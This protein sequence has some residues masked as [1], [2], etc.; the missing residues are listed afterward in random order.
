MSFLFCRQKFPSPALIG[1]RF[2][3]HVV[4]SISSTALNTQNFRQSGSFSKDCGASTK[5]PLLCY[6]RVSYVG[7]GF[8]N[9]RQNRFPATP[10]NVLIGIYSSTKLYHTSSKAIEA[11]MLR[12]WDT[13][14]RNLRPKQINQY[15]GLRY[16][17]RIVDNLL[18]HGLLCTFVVLKWRAPS[19]GQLPRPSRTTLILDTKRRPRALIEVMKPLTNG[20]WTHTIMQER[21]N[22]LLSEMTQVFFMLHT[23]NGIPFSRSNSRAA[24]GRLSKHGSSWRTLLREAEGKA[25]HLLKGLPRPWNLRN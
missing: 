21:L 19:M 9:F 7:F 20:P 5:L 16:I 25:N 4:P 24:S 14:L 22:A 17:F 12:K 10:S 13:W 2:G 1:Q 3:S 23:R 18:F 6:H 8:V 11:A 15:F